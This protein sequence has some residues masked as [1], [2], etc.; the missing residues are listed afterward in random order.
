YLLQGRDRPTVGAL[1]PRH[2]AAGAAVVPED[3]DTRGSPIRHQGCLLAPPVGPDRLLGAPRAASLSLAVG[4]P[5]DAP[6]PDRIEFRD[7]SAR[8]SCGGFPRALRR[9]FPRADARLFADHRHF[10]FPDPRCLRRDEPLSRVVDVRP[11]AL[12]PG[13]AQVP[14]LPPFRRSG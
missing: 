11:L 5:Y 9:T 7:L 13:Y 14:Q 8:A 2:V 4:V 1:G 3:P 10:H 6:L 12:D